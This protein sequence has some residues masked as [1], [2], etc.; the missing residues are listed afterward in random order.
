MRQSD[1]VRALGLILLYILAFIAVV[2]LCFG[3]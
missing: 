2:V 1:E 3:H